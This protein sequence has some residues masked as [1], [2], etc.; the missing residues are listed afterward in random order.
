M[1]KK[2]RPAIMTIT[3]RRLKKFTVEQC[4]SYTRFNQQP[5]DN[6][7]LLHYFLFHQQFLLNTT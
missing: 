7:P 1:T 4:C 6:L 5:A 2:I 3:G